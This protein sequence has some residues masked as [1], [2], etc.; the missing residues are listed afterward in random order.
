MGCLRARS[1]CH[2]RHCPCRCRLSAAVSDSTAP[3]PGRD[4]ANDRSHSP[5]RGE[6]GPTSA[7]HLSSVVG[8]V[9]G[10]L[11]KEP[12]SVANEELLGDFWPETLQPV[13][14]LDHRILAA[15]DVGI[16]AGVANHVLKPVLVDILVDPFEREGRYPH[17]TANV[18]RRGVLEV[19]PLPVEG[20]RPSPPCSH[21][22]SII[23]MS[24]PIQ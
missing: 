5:A 1:L 11:R 24:G 21:H 12:P 15:F 6:F 10:S 3:R 20:A 7:V 4:T 23:R 16:V 22:M 18:E 14:E 8:D 2:G 13:R 19:G 9:T 17:V